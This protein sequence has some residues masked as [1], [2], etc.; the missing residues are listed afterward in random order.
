MS[1]DSTALNKK[2]GFCTNN[3]FIFRSTPGINPTAND[4]INDVLNL[5]MQLQYLLLVFSATVDLAHSWSP[6]YTPFDISP[7]A[8]E[9]VSTSHECIERLRHLLKKLSVLPARSK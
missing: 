3:C 7:N 6:S 2:Y 9:A 8:T 5:I 4:Q 1:C